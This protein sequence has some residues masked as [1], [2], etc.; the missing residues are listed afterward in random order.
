MLLVLSILFC[1]EIRIENLEVVVGLFIF[2]GGGIEGG[3]GGREER[4]I[5]I[6]AVVVRDL[7]CIFFRG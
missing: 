1:F 5:L 3:R 7:I 6:S 4:R 2:G